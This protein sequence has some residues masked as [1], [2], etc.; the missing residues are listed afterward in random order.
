M[1]RQLDGFH[2]PILNEGLGWRSKHLGV[3]EKV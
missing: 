1:Q 3:W 2:L